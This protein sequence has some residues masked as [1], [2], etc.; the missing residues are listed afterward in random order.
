M[1]LG[2]VELKHS[3]DASLAEDKP[4]WCTTLTLAHTPVSFKIDS[5]A[6][7]SVISEATYETLQNKPKLST[8]KNILQS[9]GGV[10]ATR[11]QFLAK[12]KAH[13][14]GQLQN[15]CFRVVVVRTNGENLLS[16]TVA[17]KLGLIKRIEEICVFNSVVSLKGEPV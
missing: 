16:R 11:G 6:D 5:G 4:P 12:I 3:T 17:T 13:V 8:V 14:N 1:F 9:P 7:T 10:V 2:S 15:C